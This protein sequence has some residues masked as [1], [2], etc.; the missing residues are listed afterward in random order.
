MSEFLSV[1]TYLLSHD[2]DIAELCDDLNRVKDQEQPALDKAV[3]SFG[4]NTGV[5][6][7]GN[8]TYPLELLRLHFGRLGSRLWAVSLAL[9][10]VPF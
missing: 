10:V 4:C 3:E 5:D 9:L 2:R 6:S 7:D 1:K 8:K